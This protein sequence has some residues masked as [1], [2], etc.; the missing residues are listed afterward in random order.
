MSYCTKCKINWASLSSQEGEDD[1]VYEVCPVC[2]NDM[3]LID[4]I[5]GDRFY[6]CPF[7]GNI[8][9]AR[10]QQRLE[11]DL[12]VPALPKM[13]VPKNP[14]V[15]RDLWEQKQLLKEKKEDAYLDAYHNALSM[16]ASEEQAMEAGR[17]AFHSLTN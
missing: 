14:I 16:G 5:E 7:T 1:E 13:R 2:K 15:S 4:N 17:F 3:D 9:N 6:F 12:S 11:R 8:I 10:T